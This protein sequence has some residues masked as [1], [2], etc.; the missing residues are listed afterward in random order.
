VDR[1]GIDAPVMANEAAFYG[2][3]I[4]VKLLDALGRKWQLSTVQF[5]FTLPR[6]FGLEYVAED[7]RKHQP[8]MVHRALY[9]SIERFFGI[10]IE[11]YA[12]AFPV[13]LAPVQAVVLPITDRQQDY[14]KTVHAKLEAA[15]LRVHLDD[16]KE[17]VN[18]KIRDA[19][20]Q[21]VPYMLVVGDREAESGAVAVR[22]RKHG[23]LG[24]KPLEQFMDEMCQLVASKSAVD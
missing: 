22:H 20:M 16:R 14:A 8:L 19:Q 9:G 17:K 15:G 7:G 11:H 1:L 12:G 21:K 2:P 4:D 5:D 3:K 13:W 10:L 6:R 24:A 18:L 23:D